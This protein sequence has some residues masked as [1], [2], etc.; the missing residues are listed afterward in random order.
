MKKIIPFTILIIAS[1]SVKCS[2]NKKANP[3]NK[4]EVNNK[5]AT[6]ILNFPESGEDTLK[7]SYFADTVIYI[8]LETTTESFMDYIM[9]LWMDDSVILV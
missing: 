3:D 8:P 4:S 5:I 1:L 9:Q 7:A 6:Q 2:Y